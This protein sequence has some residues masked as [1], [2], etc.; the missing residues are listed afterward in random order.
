MQHAKGNP[1]NP[2]RASDITETGDPGC[3]TAEAS[4]LGWPVG[5]WPKCIEVDAKIGN[6]QPMIRKRAIQNRDGELISAVYWQAFGA[7]V[8]AVLND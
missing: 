4:G 7:T 1:L 5:H 3:F 6:G 2:L 8:L